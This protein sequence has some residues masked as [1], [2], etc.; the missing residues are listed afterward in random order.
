MAQCMRHDVRTE[1]GCLTSGLEGLADPFNGLPVPFDNGAAG[2]PE[3]MPTA[4]MGQEA[5]R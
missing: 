4:Q 1:P 2:K 5:G 3:P